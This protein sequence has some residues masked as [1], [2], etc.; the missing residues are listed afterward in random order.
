M[1]NII[2]TFQSTSRSTLFQTV[3]IPFLF[4]ATVLISQ[5]GEVTAYTDCMQMVQIPTG[6]PMGHG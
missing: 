4:K 1:I 6:P 2:L 3:V 5:T